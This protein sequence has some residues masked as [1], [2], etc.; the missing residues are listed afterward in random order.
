MDQIWNKG[1]SKKNRLYGPNS[2]MIT[3]GLLNSFNCFYC[4]TTVALDSNIQYI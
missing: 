4:S 3:I 2:K 1:K